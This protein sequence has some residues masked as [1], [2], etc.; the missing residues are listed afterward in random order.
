MHETVQSCQQ[1]RIM[2]HPEM[3]TSFLN[4]A[5]IIFA[6]TSFF[7]PFKHDPGITTFLNCSSICLSLHV[8]HF[9]IIDIFKSECAYALSTKGTVQH[10][11]FITP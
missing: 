3:L 5:T 2:L 8:D 11:S 6:F 9:F 4:K 1:T 7:L 10:K